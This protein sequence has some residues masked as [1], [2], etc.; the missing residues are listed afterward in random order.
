MFFFSGRAIR[1]GQ[2]L[3]DS[4]GASAALSTEVAIMS[5]NRALMGFQ[6]P[7]DIFR[8]PEA[9][10]R[11]FRKTPSDEESPFD[12]VLTHS[13]SDFAVMGMHFKLGIYEHQSAGAIQGLIDLLIKHPAI[14]ERPDAID[15]VVIKAYQPAFGI[16]GNTAKRNPQTRQSADHSM[17]YIIGR[18]LRKAAMSKRDGIS[19]ADSKDAWCRWMLSP[20]DYSHEA[21]QDTQTRALMQK[22]HFLHGGPEYDR[23]YP[24]GIPTS[25]DIIMTDGTSFSSGLVM[26]PLGHSRSTQPYLKAVLDHKFQ[27]FG[28]LAMDQKRLRR[29]MKRL[30]GQRHA[31]NVYGLYRDFSKLNQHEPLDQQE[32]TVTS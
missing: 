6:G 26:Y 2:Q 12:I 15:R 18:L 19:I 17:V 3:S 7:K 31:D 14:S 32:I 13:G 11:T 5:M 8:N 10:F 16:I 23:R 29:Y 21:I 25:V 24:D 28:E 4:K 22:I 20:L 27:L 1:A 9:I 30:T